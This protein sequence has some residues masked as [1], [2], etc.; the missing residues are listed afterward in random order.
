MGEYRYFC[1]E[2]FGN[3]NQDYSTPTYDD[4]NYSSGSEDCSDSDNDGYCDVNGSEYS[5]DN[6]SEENY[7]ED[8][9]G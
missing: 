3:E 2:T 9:Q 8:Y 6:Y 1:S 5:D 4:S 7:V